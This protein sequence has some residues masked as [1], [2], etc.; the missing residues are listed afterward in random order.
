MELDI[1][2]GARDGQ[3]WRAR[4]G[5]PRDEQWQKVIDNLAPLT[6]A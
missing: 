3:E 1:G 5:M 4:L 6:G 2:S